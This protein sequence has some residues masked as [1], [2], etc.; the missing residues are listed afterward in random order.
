M[1]YE[2]VDGKIARLISRQDID[3]ARALAERLA[4]E[5]G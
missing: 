2:W 3:E 4:R 5:R 1:I